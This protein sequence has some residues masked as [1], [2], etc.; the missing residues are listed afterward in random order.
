MQKLI[1]DP[2]KSGQRMNIVCFIS[3]SGT[4]YRE[5]V[6]RNPD[7]NYLVFTN[8]PGCDGVAIAKQNKHAVIE[9]S[10]VSY[11]EEAKK[12]Y[13]PAPVPRNCPERV[14][15]EQAVCRLIE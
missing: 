5:I 12:Q 10:Q 15:Y 4:N 7:H 11:L 13:A 8:R 2:V 1:Y 9:L 14:Q 6:A 3:G